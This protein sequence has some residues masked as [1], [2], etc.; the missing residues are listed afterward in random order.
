MKELKL[1]PEEAMA[2]KFLIQNTR[3]SEMK[4]DSQ[5]VSLMRL[6]RRIKEALA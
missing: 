4:T 1:T 2:L 5:A 3:V 6:Y